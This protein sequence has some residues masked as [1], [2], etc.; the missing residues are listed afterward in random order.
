MFF[1]MLFLCCL[2]L[3]EELC[4]MPW[5][6]MQHECLIKC[7]L[8][9]KSQKRIAYSVGPVGKYGECTLHSGHRLLSNTAVTC[10]LLHP[11]IFMTINKI[12]VFITLIFQAF[13]VQDKQSTANR[14]T[15][16]INKS[17]QK[18]RCLQCG[19]LLLCKDWDSWYKLTVHSMWP[20]SLVPVTLI[21]WVFTQYCIIILSILSLLS[22]EY[23]ANLDS[24][25][26]ILVYIINL[27]EC[28]DIVYMHVFSRSSVSSRVGM[29]EHESVFKHFASHDVHIFKVLFP[30]ITSWC[31]TIFYFFILLQEVNRLQFEIDKQD[32]QYSDNQMMW[33][34]RFDW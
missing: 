7:D 29:H 23:C 11:I 34:E 33:A 10:D 12:Q 2:L 3:G 4:C 13:A 6:P 26:I 32:G 24:S 9:N 31:Y 1:I 15:K 20:C 28:L 5:I 27:E 25:C 17:L 18:V 19:V 14:K 16:L 30:C 21:L 8:E 22:G